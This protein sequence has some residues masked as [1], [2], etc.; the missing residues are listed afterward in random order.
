MSIT[1]NQVLCSEVGVINFHTVLSLFSP[2]L[3]PQTL[4][5]R[6]ILGET[7]GTARCSY[8]IASLTRSGTLQLIIGTGLCFIFGPWF[9]VKE[10]KGGKNKRYNTSASASASASASSV[11]IPLAR[12]APSTRSGSSL[13]LALSI[14]FKPQR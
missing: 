9:E 4:Y 13:G 3:W 7:D 2:L 12:S 11:H 1:K 8:Y 14:I 6:D 10:E 5:S